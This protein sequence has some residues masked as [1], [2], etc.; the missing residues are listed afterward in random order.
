MPRCPEC[1]STEVH[2]VL[3]LLFPVAAQRGRGRSRVYTVELA[4]AI[5]FENDPDTHFRCNGCGHVWRSAN[6]FAGM[7]GPP[8]RVVIRR[9]RRRPAP[10]P[11]ERAA[12]EPEAPAGI[13]L[14]PR[15]R[16]DLD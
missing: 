12:P 13:P 2:V 10:S 15:R 6:R 16:V 11:A 5:R 8:P 7:D 3:N 14:V 4:S 1:R 9:H